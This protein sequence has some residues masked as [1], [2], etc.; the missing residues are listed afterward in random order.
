MYAI[1]SYYEANSLIGKSIDFGI[2]VV[3][4]GDITQIHVL[5]GNPI[6]FGVPVVDKGDLSQGSGLIGKKIYS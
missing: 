3:D 2:P 6:Y 1:R 4:K 5:E